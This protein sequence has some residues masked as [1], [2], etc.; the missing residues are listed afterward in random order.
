MYC[1]RRDLRN[2]LLCQYLLSMHE[3]NEFGSYDVIMQKSSF[4]RPIIYGV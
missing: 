3:H 4:N 2:A 1:S